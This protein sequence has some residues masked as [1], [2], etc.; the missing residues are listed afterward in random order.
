MQCLVDYE[1]IFPLSFFDIMIDIMVHNVKEI[2]ILGPFFLHDMFSFERYMVL[3]K[4]C[5]CANILALKDALLRVMGP[6]R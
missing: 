2:G 1:L 3:F 4:K 5:V 6:M